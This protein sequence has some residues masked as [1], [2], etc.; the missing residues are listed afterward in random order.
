[1]PGVQL[2]SN[3]TKSAILVLAIGSHSNV[4]WPTTCLTCTAT[5]SPTLTLA[6]GPRQPAEM[7]CSSCGPDGCNCL[8]QCCCKLLRLTGRLRSGMITRFMVS[9]RPCHDTAA[10]KCPSLLGRPSNRARCT[11]PTSKAFSSAWPCLYA[12]KSSASLLDFTSAGTSSASDEMQDSRAA[13]G[14]NCHLHSTV[15]K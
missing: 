8:L 6:T 13:D 11:R 2:P 7:S 1:M 5:R 3:C 14:S 4:L 9:V 15:L 12:A 10:L